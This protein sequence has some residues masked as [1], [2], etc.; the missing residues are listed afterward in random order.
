MSR[1]IPKF[2][3]NRYY[4]LHPIRHENDN[5]DDDDEYIPKYVVYKLRSRLFSIIKKDQVYTPKIIRK[6]L[7]ILI[8]V[9]KENKQ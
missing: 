5:H 2:I 4:F 7:R 1:S 3:I 8:S 6:Y 9:S